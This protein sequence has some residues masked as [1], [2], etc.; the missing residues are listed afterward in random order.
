MKTLFIVKILIL[1]LLFAEAQEVSFFEK[2]NQTNTVGMMVLGTWA[3]SNMAIGTYGWASQTGDRKYFHQ[4][5][6]FWNTINLSIAGF[7]LYQSF[8][9]DIS[10]RTEAKLF[11]KHIQTENLYLINAGLDVL[12]VGT[13]FYLKHLSTRKMNRQDQLLGYGNAILLQGSFLFL[14]DLVMYGIQ[15]SARINYLDN[16]NVSFFQNG[17]MLNYSVSL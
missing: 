13:G 2:S 1:S 14:F 16:F 5:N 8:Q 15:R 6:F 17:M 4:M 11:K 10:T 9:L 3:V 12:Y 7:A